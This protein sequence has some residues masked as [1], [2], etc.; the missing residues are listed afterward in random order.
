MP[1]ILVFGELDQNGL[2]GITAELLALARSLAA[3]TGDPVSASL[4]G[5]SVGN[6][7]EHA[8][9]MGADKVY[10]VQSPLLAEPQIDAHL[11]AIEQV[12]RSADPS[13]ILIGRTPLGRDVGPRLAF[14][15]AAAVAQDCVEVSVNPETGRVNATRPVYGGNAMAN[16]SFTGDGV[17]VV[18]ARPKT[19][20]A[21]EPDPNRSG[22]IE[23]FP[24]NLDD[25]VIKGPPRRNRLPAVRG[26]PTRR[27]R[28]RRQRRTRT[29]RPRTLRTTTGPQRPA[30]RRPRSLPRSLRRRLDRPQ[31]PG[32]THR[33]DHH[34][35]T[36]HHRRHLRRQPA[37]GR[38][39]RLQKHRRHQPR[40]RRQHLQILH[41]RRR[42]RL[43]QDTP[44]LHRNPPRTPRRL[45]NPEQFPRTHKS[46]TTKPNTEN[47]TPTVIPA[48]AG[49]HS[50]KIQ[51]RPT[52]KTPCYTT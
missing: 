52:T 9:A 31:P 18:I 12:A 21:G 7:A 8:I 28:R 17:Q 49:I 37:H 16:V 15:L 22:D 23:D 35:R 3:Q 11:S 48:N 13:I 45:T 46:T 4:Q 24:A 33:Q 1:G 32:R 36:L 30:R 34:T 25:S 50:P 41:L 40:R 26:R 47:N 2:A 39:L 14:R 29:R 43:E 38:L 20:E 10:R 42:R 27:C 51:P 6:E 44:L 5:A 19:F